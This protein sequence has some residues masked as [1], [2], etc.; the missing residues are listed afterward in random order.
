[1]IYLKYSANSMSFIELDWKPKVTVNGT[2]TDS[3]RG[4]SYEK[5]MSS[6]RSWEI[7]IS[8]DSIDTAAKLDF[9]EA[10][11]CNT[12]RQISFD[13]TNW[14]DVVIT[15]PGDL[16]IEF[17]ENAR[18]LPQI[19]ITLKRKAPGYSRASGENVMNV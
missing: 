3:L 8:A 13:G 14:I 9:L 18:C 12:E 7:T 19:K 1:M 15:S 11:F 6:K 4:Y 2:V 16:P 10:F 17:L 5:I